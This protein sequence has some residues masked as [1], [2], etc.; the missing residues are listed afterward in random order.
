MSNTT[1]PINPGKEYKQYRSLINYLTQKAKPDEKE[2]ARKNPL[3]FYTWG[4]MKLPEEYL[5]KGLKEESDSKYTK[6]LDFNV[7]PQDE[8]EKKFLELYLKYYPTS[9]NANKIK[10]LLANNG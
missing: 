6:L 3:N 4:L 5:V 10:E 9:L 8:D 7:K 1:G 2:F